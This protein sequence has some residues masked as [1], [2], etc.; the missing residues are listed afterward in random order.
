MASSEKK[1]RNDI[2]KRWNERII[3]NE[4][5]Q[6]GEEGARQYLQKYG[7]SI[8]NEKLLAFA[9]YAEEMDCE[10]F[11]DYMRAQMKKEK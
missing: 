2:I 9:E 11:A 1:K 5:D 10:E 3:P 7:R 6:M 4:W 8:G